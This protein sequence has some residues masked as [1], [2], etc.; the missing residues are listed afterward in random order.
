[1]NTSEAIEY[2]K[3][4]R[5][6]HVYFVEYLDEGHSLSD[7]IDESESLEEAIGDRQFHQDCVDNYNEVIKAIEE[8]SK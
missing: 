7:W 1:M 3:S 5:D 4:C 6:T 8:V 2:I